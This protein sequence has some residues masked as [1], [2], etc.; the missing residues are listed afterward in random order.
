M[1]S[2][3]MA[4]PVRVTALQAVAD[5]RIASAKTTATKTTTAKTV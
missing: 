2:L 1:R 3:D 4:F 5:M